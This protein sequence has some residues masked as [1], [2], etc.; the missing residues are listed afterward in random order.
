MNLLAERIQELETAELSK[1][2]AALEQRDCALND[3]ILDL[4]QKLDCYD[5]YP[6]L[7]TAE[8]YAR[9]E[10][11]N[12]YQIPESEPVLKMFLYYRCDPNDRK[13]ADIPRRPMALSG[14]MTRR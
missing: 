9:K 12:R 7:S 10:F 13:A 11:L 2:K 14:V 5:F 8:E 4:T 6:E 3:L 1:F